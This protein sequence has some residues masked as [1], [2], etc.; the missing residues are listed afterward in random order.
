MESIRKSS[1]V[2]ILLSLAFAWA[3]MPATQ[4]QE[5][6]A[7]TTEVV[8][9]R[10]KRFAGSALNPSVYIDNEQVARLG[11]GRFFTLR[12]PA[13]RHSFTSN[14]TNA[15]R[16]HIELKSGGKTYLELVLMPSVGSAWGKVSWRLVPAEEVD[17]KGALEKLKP[18]DSQWLVE[19]PKK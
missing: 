17:A 8:I 7:Q 9:Y 10:P 11:N 12:L 6:P 13:G 19:E 5:V 16:T 2:A 1:L 14:T 18:L 15:P 3:P 4:S